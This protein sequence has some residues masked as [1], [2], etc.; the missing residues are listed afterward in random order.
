ML[1]LNIRKFQ[2]YKT[3]VP[4]MQHS[5]TGSVGQVERRGAKGRKV[6]RGS[7]FREFMWWELL[8][9]LNEFNAFH[10]REYKI[11]RVLIGQNF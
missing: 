7:K 10:S 3:I 4:V 8:N 9:K 6:L 2:D 5:D 1:N 11:I